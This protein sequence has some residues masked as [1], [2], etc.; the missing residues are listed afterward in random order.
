MSE[1]VR[2][3]EKE[4]KEWLKRKDK[5]RRISTNR[6]IK[7]TKGVWRRCPLQVQPLDGGCGID[8]YRMKMKAPFIA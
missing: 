8:C 5:P 6:E 1:F 2:I 7:Q 4:T 3:G